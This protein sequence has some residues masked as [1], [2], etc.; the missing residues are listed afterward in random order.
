MRMYQEGCSA[1][2]RKCK[3][4]SD[5]CYQCHD[6]RPELSCQQCGRFLTRDDIARGAEHCSECESV[7]CCECGGFFPPMEGPDGDLNSRSVAD[8]GRCLFCYIASMD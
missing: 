5:F 7:W 6:R 1:Y 4:G 2:G 8:Y 3:N